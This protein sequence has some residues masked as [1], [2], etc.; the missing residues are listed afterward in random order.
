VIMPVLA[1][2]M[3]SGQY[4]LQLD[5]LYPDGRTEN[6]ASYRFVVVTS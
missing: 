6:A 2:R 1:H 4:K 3:N 5:N